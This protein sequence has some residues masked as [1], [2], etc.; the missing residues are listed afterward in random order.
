MKKPT[1][2]VRLTRTRLI[3]LRELQKLVAATVFFGMGNQVIL[4][5]PS[6][7]TSKKIKAA[8]KRRYDQVKKIIVERPGFEP[9]V[10]A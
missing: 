7:M 4:T 8:C 5:L 3:A 9:E 2:S 6:S 10:L 1:R